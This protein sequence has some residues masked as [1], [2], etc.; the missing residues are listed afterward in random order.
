M[1]DIELTA[2]DAGIS[3]NS[4]DSRNHDR[5]GRNNDDGD[6]GEGALAQD[7]VVPSLDQ[8]IK[9]SRASNRV[10]FN[11]LSFC[12]EAGGEQAKTAM[13]NHLTSFGVVSALMGTFFLA[14]LQAPPVREGAGFDHDGWA[15][16]VYA[17]AAIVAFLC[18]LACIVLVVVLYAYASLYTAE[19]FGMFLYHYALLGA[20]VPPTVTSASAVSGML[21][22]V[23]RLYIV[24][25]SPVWVVAAVITGLS[26]LI[27]FVVLI[28]MDVRTTRFRRNRFKRKLT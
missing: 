22:V 13:E 14:G 25:G 8:L 10:Y 23:L 1:E 4:S 26:A 7:G 6:G 17:H 5:G 11:W 24:Y 18:N 15:V 19:E 27:L 21:A 2:S 12:Q 3:D 28:V 9:G 16:Q 20:S